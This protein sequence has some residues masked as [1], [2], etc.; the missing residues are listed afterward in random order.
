M[1][2]AANGTAGTSVVHAEQADKNTRGFSPDE[3][4]ARADLYRRLG[5]IN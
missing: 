1:A 5:I 4:A 3:A 2:K